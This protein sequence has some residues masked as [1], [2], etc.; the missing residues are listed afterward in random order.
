VFDVLRYGASGL[1]N[2]DTKPAEVLRAIR[3]VAE[4]EALLSPSVTRRV[5][6][7]FATR[8]TWMVRPHSRLQSLTNRERRPS[9]WSAKA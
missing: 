8:K 2:K 6:R 5:V 7:E 9:A 4:G 3:L 1:L